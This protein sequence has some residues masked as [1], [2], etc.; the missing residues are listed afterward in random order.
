MLMPTFDAIL[1]VEPLKVNFNPYLD[2]EGTI[3]EP[4]ETQ[5]S[6][7]FDAMMKVSKNASK[8][9][10]ALDGVTDPEKM[11]AAMAKLPDGSLSGMLALMNKPYADLCSGFPSEEQIGKLPPRVRLAFFGWLAGELNPEGSGAASTTA[12]QTGS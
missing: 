9:V 1:V 7:F 8:Q 10:K 4:S 2:L 12:P 3:P 5:I 11:A 6:T